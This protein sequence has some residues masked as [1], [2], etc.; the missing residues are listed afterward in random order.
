M[1]GQG[2]AAILSLL[3]PFLSLSQ[4]HKHSLSLTELAL[5]KSYQARK[6]YFQIS[7]STPD[8][9]PLRLQGA[10]EIRKHVTLP[11]SQRHRHS[12]KPRAVI[13]NS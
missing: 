2:R 5:D 7:F 13:C 11:T 9:P 4:R 8:F 3:N 6:T 12:L 1:A 10:G